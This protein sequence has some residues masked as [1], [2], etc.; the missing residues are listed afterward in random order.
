MTPMYKSSAITSDR[1]IALLCITL[2]LAHMA[3]LL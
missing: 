2:A 3:T 1:I